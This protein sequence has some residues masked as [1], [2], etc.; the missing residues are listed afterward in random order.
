MGEVCFLPDGL[1]CCVGQRQV[2]LR[3]KADLSGAYLFYALQSP[4]VRHQIF[5]N[6]GTG[7]TVSN[8]RI[9]V[10][11]ALNIPRQKNEHE[12]ANT[13]KALDD[14][15]DLN[16]RMNETLETMARALFKDWFI[17]FGPTRAKMAMRGEDPQKENV[18]RE[19]YL[20]PEIWNLFPDRLDADGK[21]EGWT[22]KSLK[23]LTMKIGSGAT[24]RGGK[25]V[26]VQDGTSLIRSQNVYDH[27]FSWG[28]LAHIS[29]E[30]AHKLRNVTVEQGDVLINITGD[31]ILR[32][33]VVPASVL[34]ARVNQH[35]SI[36]RAS[37]GVPSRFLHQLLVMSRSKE[38][39]L[40]YDAGGS[41]KAITKGHLEGFPVDLPPSQ[42]LDAFNLLTAPLFARV[43]AN[44]GENQSLA[45]LRDL[46]LPKLMSGEVRVA[47]AE[48]QVEAVA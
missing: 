13:L 36:V 10:L 40:G 30:D 34:P 6:E 22:R 2:L 5:W 47:A 20:A 32:T 35:V 11:K 39:L 12:I 19:P 8:V 44:E 23:D 42:I 48:K 15:I 26:Y 17:D 28:G 3:P 45:Q 1:E 27:C 33:C 29:D 24:P 46:L 21:P 7:S 37:E 16:R 43:E 9:P 25:E 41:R 18:A 4:Y 38:I 31:S 14:K